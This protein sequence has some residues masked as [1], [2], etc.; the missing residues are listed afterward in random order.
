M[1]IQSVRENLR[2]EI[3]QIY[4][5]TPEEGE[6][7]AQS[8]RE[9][10]EGYYIQ[11]ATKG[12]IRYHQSVYKQ[13]V[14][15]RLKAAE[16]IWD[17]NRQ[18]IDSLNRQ[19]K[20]AG[21]IGKISPIFLYERI[22]NG[23]SRTDYSNLVNFS[24]QARRYRQQFID[25]LG[26]KNAFSSLR[27]FTVMKNEPD[28]EV[29]DYGEYEEMLKKYSGHEPDSLDVSD[30]PRFRYLQESVSTSLMRLLPDLVILIFMGIFFF[31]CAL[32]AVLRYDVR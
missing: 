19:K 6:F 14:P 7:N 12:A 5:N 26:S 23:L 11:F 24:S 2:K 16:D 9:E 28:F 10:P 20:V 31:A 29:S 22:M 21:W 15:L 17:I 18:Y 4:S 8:D 25:Y 13:M 27:Y 30:V 1:Q 32:V 3:Y